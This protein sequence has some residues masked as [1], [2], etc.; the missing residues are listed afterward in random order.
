ML[1]TSLLSSEIDT[2]PLRAKGKDFNYFKNYHHMAGDS[3]V[4]DRDYGIESE[5]LTQ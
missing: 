1:I 2:K 3:I 4:C 5:F